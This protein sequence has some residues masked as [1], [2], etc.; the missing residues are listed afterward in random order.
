MQ[1]H[2]II[3][4]Y[5]DCCMCLKQRIIAFLRIKPLDVGGEVKET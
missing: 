4:A 2:Q 5:G 1:R 3:T